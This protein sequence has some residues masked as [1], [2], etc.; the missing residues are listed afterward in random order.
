MKNSFVFTGLEVFKELCPHLLRAEV[1]L[2]IKAIEL[3]NSK[4]ALDQR[5]DC[6][7][8]FSANLLVHVRI[9]CFGR[10]LMKDKLRDEIRGYS[11]KAGK[12]FDKR[13]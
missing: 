1:V 13:I 8:F 10:I 7:D 2:F 9:F 3:V 6:R 5:K 4:F 12:L 11:E